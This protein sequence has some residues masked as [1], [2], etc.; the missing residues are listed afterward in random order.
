MPL[1]K[2]PS[3]YILALM[4][5]ILF[6]LVVWMN[7]LLSLPELISEAEKRAKA[8]DA[9]P[10]PEAPGLPPANSRPTPVVIDPAL[11]ERAD[12]LNE[13]DSPPQRDLEIIAEFIQTYGKALGGNPIGDNSDITAALTG[14]EGHKGRVFPPNH[15]SI[16]NGQLIDRWGVPYWFHPNSGNQMEIRSA[17]PDKQLFTPDDIVLN[18]SPSGLG[19]TPSAESPAGN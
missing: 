17:G 14:S 8:V 2:R 3:T 1:P 12:Q 13:Q 10:K 18:P 15:R 6:I 4:L 11:Q 5:I 19:V 9:S 16:R 7:K